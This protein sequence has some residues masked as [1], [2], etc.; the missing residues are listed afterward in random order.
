MSSLF[1][2]FG[3]TNALQNPFDIAVVTPTVVRPTLP[4][5]LGSI[6]NQGFGGRIQ[7]LVGVDRRRAPLEPLIDALAK[8]PRRRVVS[9][10][11]PGYSTSI[12]HGGLHPAKDGG[13]LRCVLT[14]LANARYVA[15]LDDDNWWELDHLSRMR[16]AIEGKAW[17]FSLRC[18]THPE[19]QRPVAIDDWESIG[20]GRGFYAKNFGGW[21]DPNCLM[22]DKLVCEPV[23]RWWALP[24]RMDPSGLAADRNVFRALK[25]YPFG[26]T[27]A[28]TVFYQLN[29]KDSM[30]PHRMK[31]FKEAYEQA[32]RPEAPSPRLEP[33][34]IHGPSA[35]EKS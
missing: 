27:R 10:F 33:V 31:R 34:Q 7:A 5:A 26:E 25:R 2:H 30:H 23:I 6:L 32:G 24:L 11:D 22:I 14:Y 12:R 16:Q 4:R 3:D 13:V 35:S 17:A 15:Y 9:L 18:F 29:P 28:V 1:Q 20:P 21:V 8:L 19:T